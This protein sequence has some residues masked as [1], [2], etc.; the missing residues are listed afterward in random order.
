[1]PIGPPTPYGDG[2]CLKQHGSKDSLSV[3]CFVNCGLWG[4]FVVCYPVSLVHL[5]DMYRTPHNS[6]DLS[7]S[8][9][10]EKIAKC[11]PWEDSPCW[12]GLAS[13]WEK[14]AD[15]PP[16]YLHTR[17][18]CPFIWACHAQVEEVA[19]YEVAKVLVEELCEKRAHRLSR[20]WTWYPRELW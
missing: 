18:I 1:M 8:P 13:K 2:V 7:V 19:V 5:T 20:W 15:I 3:S 4:D 12:R 11:E 14:Q 16:G 17:H 6:P 9:R 10:G